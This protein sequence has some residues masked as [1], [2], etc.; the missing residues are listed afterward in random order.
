MKNIFKKTA[1][2][3]LALGMMCAM[4][5][6][7]CTTKETTESNVGLTQQ[8]LVDEA[9][10]IKVTGMLPQGVKLCTTIS[11]VDGEFLS[12]RYSVKVSM[13]EDSPYEEL[14]MHRDYPVADHVNIINKREYNKAEGNTEDYTSYDVSW[15]TENNGWA[16][17]VMCVDVGF[18]KDGAEVD[19]DSELTVTLPF[20]YRKA[21]TECREDSNATA[22]ELE[23]ISDEE[24]KLNELEVISKGKT[25][26]GT[27]QYKTNGGGVFFVGNDYQMKCYTSLYEYE[28]KDVFAPDVAE[29]ISKATE[30]DKS[31]AVEITVEEGSMLPY[32]IYAVAM[33]ILV[34]VVIVIIIKKSKNKS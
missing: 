18:V 16:M 31:S 32:I 21:L 10:N 27:F 2:V 15:V 23:V 20:D 3:A 17:P 34:L 33:S 14:Y 22:F 26:K 12:E 8:T 19:V 28:P 29:R 30:A 13:P 7:A 5:C 9:T 4:S 11:L 25:K 6:T 1:G 24:E